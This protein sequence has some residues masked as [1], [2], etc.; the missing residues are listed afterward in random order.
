MCCYN[1][2]NKMHCEERCDCKYDSHLFM[3][4]L[5][6]YH[7]RFH[8]QKDIT[9]RPEQMGVLFQDK[10]VETTVERAKP[11][12]VITADDVSDDESIFNSCVKGMTKKRGQ[13]NQLGRVRRKKANDSERKQC[14]CPCKRYGGLC[15]M[16][17]CKICRNE[18]VLN[19]C[20]STFEC[21][22]PRC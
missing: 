3:F 12:N 20:Y 22:S 16:T 13:M 5:E 14:A 2:C 7:C 11:T 1:G 9:A 19:I 15:E 21:T 4:C 18:Y 8:K 10:M 6:H 17:L